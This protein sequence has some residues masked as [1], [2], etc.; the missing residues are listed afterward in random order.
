M[1]SA[2]PTATI[3]SDPLSLACSA[4]MVLLF[5]LMHKAWISIPPVRVHLP[6][7][8]TRSHA[9]LFQRA[10]SPLGHR[11]RSQSLAT[12]LPP[13]TYSRRLALQILHHM[14]NANALPIRT[15]HDILPP[16]PHIPTP[17]VQRHPAKRC[18]HLQPLKS[19]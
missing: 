14:T 8:P 17:L 11:T 16:T 12:R 4:D 15:L 1:A 7:L 5:V 6:A 19:G 13:P 9:P 18:A 3:H 10:R 2:F